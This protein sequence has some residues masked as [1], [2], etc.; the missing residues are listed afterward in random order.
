[1][2]PHIP[3]CAALALLLPACADRPKAPPLSADS[4]Y[5]NDEIGLR[6]LA[7]QG[8]AMQARATLPPGEL[9]KP[10]IL[11]AYR[12]GGAARPSEF[13]L[14]VGNADEST[15]LGAFL[16]E[17]QVGAGKWA[18]ASAPKAVTVNGRAATQYVLTRTEGKTEVRREATAF[19]TAGRVYFF[20]VTYAAND[21]ATRESVR[22]SIDSIVWTK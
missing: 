4:V 20:L 5:Q 10:T 18:Q 8:W 11:V 6:F 2:R 21:P 19:L 9:R 13:D 17:Y 22:S 14:L 12:R 16:A 1:M 3:A 15:D 7:P